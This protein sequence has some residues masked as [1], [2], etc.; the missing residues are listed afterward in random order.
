MLRVTA[1]FLI[2]GCLMGCQ[3]IERDPPR[4]VTATPDGLSTLISAANS[5]QLPPLSVAHQ[6][7]RQET[8][9]PVL[10]SPV[11]TQPSCELVAEQNT[12]PQYVVKATLD[13][14][15]H[16]L[17]AE[18]EVYYTNTTGLPQTALVFQV[19]PN[20]E[21]GFFV[22]QGV[23]TED[24]RPIDG[25]TLDITR[26]SVPLSERLEPNCT[27]RLKMAYRLKI[28][29]VLDGYYGRFG[30]LGFTE[31]Q[32]NLGHWMPLV[33]YFKKADWYV[34]RPHFVGEQTIAD[35]SDFEVT[36]AIQNAPP[37]IDVAGPGQVQVLGKNQ[38]RFKLERARDLSVSVGNGF[39]RTSQLADD[40][41]VIELY[42]FP[43]SAPNGLNPASQ[44]L[45]AAAEAL[46]LYEELFGV[47]YPY[48]RLVIVEGDFPDGMEFSGLVFVGEAWFRVW[49]GE[50]NDWLTVITVHEVAHQWWYTLIGNDP[51]E[52]PYMDEAFATYSEYLYFQRYYG[53]LTEWWWNFRV[54]GYDTQSGMVDADIYRYD[55]ARG[56]INAAYLRGAEMLHTMRTDLG[57]DAFFAWLK[58]YVDANLYQ[59]AAPADLWSQLPTE[60][61]EG[62]LAVR[63]RFFERWGILSTPAPLE[64]LATPSG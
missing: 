33:A 49:K 24:N 37:T 4:V 16:T 40:G 19:E 10:A 9:T 18:Q 2:V 15:E 60:K 47:A 44:A 36:L 42:Y 62:S 14:A 41:T 63:Q 58:S 45:K 51:S 56:Y 3:S 17:Q 54:R 32:I 5:T 25:V 52:Y 13:W 59:V 27:L 21:T 64:S 31:R 1:A 55:N 46:V 8:P 34:P 48:G 30:Y 43:S 22:L 12:R 39:R 7:L 11:P 61:Y 35:A 26:M 38:W 29:P 20:R 28:P 50:P 57:D 6:S 23:S 53:D